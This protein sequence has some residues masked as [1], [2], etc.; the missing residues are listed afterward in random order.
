MPNIA[1]VNVYAEVRGKYSRPAII[2]VPFELPTVRSRASSVAVSSLMSRRSSLNREIML[3]DNPE[4]KTVEELQ[5]ML[6]Q[7]RLVIYI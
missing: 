5:K 6:R 7:E 1:S 2:K 4:G 3:L